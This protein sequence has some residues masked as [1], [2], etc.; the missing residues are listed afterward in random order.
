[1]A[2][3]QEMHE[4]NTRFY[5]WINRETGELLTTGEMLKQG[6]EEYDLNDPTNILSIDEYYIKLDKP[7]RA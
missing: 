6:A 1:M 3:W 7:I 4:Q 2:T 5:K